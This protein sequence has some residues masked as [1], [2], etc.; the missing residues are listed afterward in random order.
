M[1]EE[2]WGLPA[3]PGEPRLGALWLAAQSLELTTCPPDDVGIDSRQGRTQ[4]RLGEAAIVEDP[5]P[6][7]RIVHLGQI[8]QGFVAAMMQRPAADV[9]TNALQRLGARSGIETVREDGPIRCSPPGLTGSEL[10]AQ[11]V[12]VDI[13][14]VAIPVGIFA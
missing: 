14:I 3:N 10:E 12:K 6:D 1:R 7:A 2:R 11:K 5:T 9:A 4:L 13:G 8:G